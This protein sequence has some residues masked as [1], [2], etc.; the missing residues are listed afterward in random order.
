MNS[1]DAVGVDGASAVNPKGEVI[2]FVDVDPE[3]FTEFSLDG[4]MIVVRGR[5]AD[6]HKRRYGPVALQAAAKRRTVSVVQ[7]DM[8]GTPLKTSTVRQRRG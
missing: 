4:D 5:G 6:P 3:L 8:A 1:M 2:L 7:V